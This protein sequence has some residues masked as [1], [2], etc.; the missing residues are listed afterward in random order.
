MQVLLEVGPPEKELKLDYHFA[1][2][3]YVRH[4]QIM[5]PHVTF[6]NS[7]P[8]SLNP[9]PSDFLSGRRGQLR[10]AGPLLPGT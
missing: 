10:P 3:C 9:G 4:I 1:K 2:P 7:I 5:R 8:D 6:L